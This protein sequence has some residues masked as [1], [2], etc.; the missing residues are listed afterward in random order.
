MRYM[1]LIV[2]GGTIG[3]LFGR[4]LIPLL[5]ERGVLFLVVSVLLIA[6]FLFVRMVLQGRTKR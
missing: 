5:L 3:F 2:V 4:Y 6:A 1:A